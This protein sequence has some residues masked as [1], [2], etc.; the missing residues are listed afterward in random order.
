MLRVYMD[1][2]S[3]REGCSEYVM[4]MACGVSVG[5]HKVNMPGPRVPRGAD[6]QVL[7]AVQASIT[8]NID[9]SGPGGR[10]IGSSRIKLVIHHP[11]TCIHISYIPQT[12]NSYPNKSEDEACE[13][14][15]ILL[16]RHNTMHTQRDILH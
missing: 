1:R 16:R 6:R 5:Q 7:V 15:V 12:L 2:H 3:T 11:P 10:G 9:R 4:K 13:A 8:M 14:K